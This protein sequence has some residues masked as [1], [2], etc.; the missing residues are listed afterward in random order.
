VF[1]LFLAAAGYISSAQ[2]LTS[3]ILFHQKHGIF[4]AARVLGMKAAFFLSLQSEALIR[5]D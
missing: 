5:F 2:F 4:D 3:A 1:G